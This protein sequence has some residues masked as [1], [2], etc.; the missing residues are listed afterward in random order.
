MICFKHNHNQ[1]VG[2]CKS[3][4]KALCLECVIEFPRGIACSSE[5]E[6]DAKE[7]VEMS[8]RGKKIYGIGQYKTNKL[9]SGVWVWLLLTGALWSATGVSFFVSNNPNYGTAV[10]ATLFS[11]ITIIV[12]RAS[13]RTGIN[14]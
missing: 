13:K 14:C 3:C 4:G 12:Y 1:S 2:L 11:I 10:L 7:L 9:A 5:C 6:E 8:E